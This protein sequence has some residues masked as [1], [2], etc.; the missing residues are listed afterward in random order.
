MIDLHSHILPNID[1]GARSIEDTIAIAEN[2]VSAGVTH[3]MCTPHINLGT[4]DNTPETISAAFNLAVAAIKKADIPLKL[5]FAS[6]VRLCPEILVLTKQN[7]L[8]FLGA[9]QGKQALLLEL[10]HSHIPPGAENLIKWLLSNNIQP[11]IP[12][13]ERNREIIADYPKARWLKQLGCIFQV[14]AGAFVNRFS[15]AVFDTVWRMQQDKLITYV[16]SDTHNIKMRPNDMK[17]AYN[18]VVAKVDQNLADAWFIEIPNVIT[19]EITW[20]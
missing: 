8:P 4:F 3:M 2:S 5:A 7:K 9:W 11:V 6:E 15:D 19:Q 16:A 1:D 12:H 13:P 17:D 20:Q 10:P 18:A 14:T